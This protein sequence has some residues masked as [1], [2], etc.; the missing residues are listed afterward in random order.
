MPI[1]KKIK[2]KF[3]LESSSSCCNWLEFHSKQSF[4]TLSVSFFSKVFF[5]QGISIIRGGKN[6]YGNGYGIL[7]SDTLI[8]SQ[9]KLESKPTPNT[10]QLQLEE[11]NLIAKTSKSETKKKSIFLLG[12]SIF[13]FFW[14]DNFEFS[15]IHRF[16]LSSNL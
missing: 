16:F 4:A 6:G 9:S 11:L 1:L 12:F 13:S 7:I 10:S 15:K 2:A 14:T 8:K 5:P 3:C